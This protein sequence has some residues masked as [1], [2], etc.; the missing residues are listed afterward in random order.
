MGIKCVLI[1]SAG[2]IICRGLTE[3]LLC[4]SDQTLN[5]HWTA[6]WLPPVSA[7]VQRGGVF[8]TA[9]LLLPHAQSWK[10]A[11]QRPWSSDLSGARVS[12]HVMLHVAVHMSPLQCR[13]RPGLCVHVET[14]QRVKVTGGHRF[15]FLKEFKSPGRRQRLTF[16]TID[17]LC[18][19]IKSLFKHP[20]VLKM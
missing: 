18:C 11:Y 6:E 9:R 19:V 10:W 14:H 15:G 17:T 7:W 5:W 1:S 2:I 4:S 12:L 3:S 8:S 13:K 20:G 16:S